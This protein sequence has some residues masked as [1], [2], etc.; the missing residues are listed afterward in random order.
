MNATI[1]INVMQLKLMPAIKVGVDRRTN[2]IVSFKNK[3]NMKKKRK[4]KANS[5]V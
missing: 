2:E 3:K 1:I 5:S 4:K